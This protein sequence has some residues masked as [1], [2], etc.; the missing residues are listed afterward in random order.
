MSTLPLNPNFP[1]PSQVPNNAIMDINGR[2]TYLGN[3]FI[4]PAN[5]DGVS[6]E[7]DTETALYYINCPASSK[8][9]L[10]L[11]QRKLASTDQVI[12]RFYLNPTISGA[13]TP[14]VPINLRP[15]SANTSVSSCASAPTASANGTFLSV[16]ATVVSIESVS[17]VIFIL[18]PGQSLLITA[19]GPADGSIV[20]QENIWYEI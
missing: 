3:S 14:A 19:Q 1:N 2:Q 5:P 15:A 7:D 10:F 11:F 8:K 12:V 18:D 17:D 16:L 20:Y 9:S 13:G 6:L 4:L